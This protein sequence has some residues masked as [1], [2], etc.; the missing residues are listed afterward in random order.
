MAGIICVETEFEV[1]KSKNKLNTNSEH[2]TKYIS[3]E[4]GIPY[5]YRR[6]ATIEEFKYYIKQFKKKEYQKYNIVYFSFHG[7]TH[8][9]CFEGSGT[10]DMNE[11]SGI[12]EGCFED[13]YVHFGSCRTLLGTEDV[14][15][16]FIE[17]TGARSVSGY[18]K[19]VNSSLCAIHD[20]GLI[21]ELLTRK[22]LTPLFK[23]LRH[24]YSGL[25]KALGF[26][27]VIR[28]K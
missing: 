20:L 14:V 16:M 27:Y 4:F 23:N 13:K 7:D 11:L 18:T 3:E 17:K 21:R 26:K 15:R 8:S 2:L 6:V 5:I 24:L 9:I 10:Y 25:E 19:S 1:T 22:S 12:C 28:V